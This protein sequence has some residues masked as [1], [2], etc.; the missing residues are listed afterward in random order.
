M[1]ISIGRGVSNADVEEEESELLTNGLKEYESAPNE[2]WIK[3]NEVQ[4]VKLKTVMDSGNFDTIEELLAVMVDRMFESC[5]VENVM[6]RKIE[7]DPDIKE[8]KQELK[9]AI[10]ELPAGLE[11]IIKDLFDK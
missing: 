5:A 2:F 10:K 11:K 1:E 3:L 8:A 6:K 9:K 7:T 4:K